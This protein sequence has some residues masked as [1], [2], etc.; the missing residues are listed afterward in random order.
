MHSIIIFA[1]GSGT[2]AQAII[3]YFKTGNNVQVS[4]IV[5]NKEGAGVLKR[6]EQE[7]I[8]VLMTNRKDM[9]SPAFLDALKEHNP[10]L[11]VLAGFLLQIPASLVHAFPGKIINV[12]PALLPKYGGKGM[13]GHHVHH[14]VVAHKEKESG[15]TIHYVDEVYDNGARILQ[16]YCP[17]TNEDSADALAA[18]IH[19]LEHFYYPRAIG[20]LLENI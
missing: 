4:L 1:S 10:S 9:D 16:A 12:H 17:V 13:Y 14:A 2:N 5:C 18:K 6:A 20:Q 8:R 19:K 15:I 7:N 3:D 11:V